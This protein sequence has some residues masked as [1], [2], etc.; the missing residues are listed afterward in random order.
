M[1][2]FGGVMR[3]CHLVAMGTSSASAL[4]PCADAKC[5]PRWWVSESLGGP[6]SQLTLSAAWTLQPA[7]QWCHVGLEPRW[8]SRD[9]RSWRHWTRHHCVMLLWITKLQSVA[10]TFR[11][12]H[13]DGP[14]TFSSRDLLVV[15]SPCVAVSKSLFSSDQCHVLV[16]WSCRDCV[17]YIVYWV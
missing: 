10:C 12:W 4:I 13:R 7:A 15:S 6:D 9:R 17:L 3:W 16:I 14:W 5:P 11:H 2:Q 1:G 8:A